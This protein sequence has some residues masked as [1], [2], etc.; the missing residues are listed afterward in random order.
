MGEAREEVDV[1]YAGDTIDIGFN[2]KYLL[3]CL[4][5][6]TG[7]TLEFHFKDRLSP[8]VMRSSNQQNHT[9]VIMPMRI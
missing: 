3:D 7:E 1:D 2:A 9:Y 6:I 8:G 5:V 4:A